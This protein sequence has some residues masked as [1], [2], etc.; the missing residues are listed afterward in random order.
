[1]I[2]AF[3]QFLINEKGY[4]LYETNTDFYFHKPTH[5]YYSTMGNIGF[6]FVDEREVDFHNGRHKIGY[7]F[8]YPI[9]C[10]GLA[11]KLI[12][13]I[14]HPRPLIRLR[15]NLKIDSKT[16]SILETEMN[17]DSMNYILS[18]V[19]F[20]EIYKAMFD[21]SIVFEFDLTRCQPH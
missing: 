1:M 8:K 4:T 13:T 10:F 21:N 2:G 3:E 20:E 9:I 17:D 6:T 19:P 12:P 18:N 16:F 7:Q 14:I 11:Q 5:P 15:R